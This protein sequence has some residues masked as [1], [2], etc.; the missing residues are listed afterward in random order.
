MTLSALLALSA[1]KKEEEPATPAPTT[2]PAA[3]PATPANNAVPA[4]VATAKAIPLES[5]PAEEQ[6]EED[7]AKDVTASNLEQKLDSLEKEM[8]SE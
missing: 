8:Q 7:A 1:C 4:T 5:I 3:Q 6:F 2:E